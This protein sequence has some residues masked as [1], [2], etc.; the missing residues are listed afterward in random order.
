MG[1]LT[2]DMHQALATIPPSSREHAWDGSTEWCQIEGHEMAFAMEIFMGAANG[3]IAVMKSGAEAGSAESGALLRCLSLGMP[4]AVPRAA[5]QSAASDLTSAFYVLWKHYSGDVR[6][7]SICARVVG[8]YYLMI[9]SRG[10]AVARWAKPFA[11]QEQMVTL[12]SCVV[13]VLGQVQL[14][15]EGRLPFA[16]YLQMV[17][18]LASAQA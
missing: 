8:F 13:A 9:A 1:K 12:E 3:C 7:R 10:A 11:G 6:Q 16:A 15:A 18:E 5:D 17:A 2:R 4:T 14:T